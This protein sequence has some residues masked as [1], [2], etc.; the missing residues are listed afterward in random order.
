MR[1]M[2]IVI[3]L[4]T[5]S[6]AF[7]QVPSIEVG[8]SD[9]ARFLAR[10]QSDAILRETLENESWQKAK[11]LS[12][13]SP[14][15]M[16]NRPDRGDCL[17]I[18]NLQIGQ[19]G[20]IGGWD[21]EV[22]SIV[23]SENAILVH[24]GKQL[25]LSGYKTSELSDKMHIRILDPVRVVGNQSFVTVLGKNATIQKIEPLPIEKIKEQLAKDMQAAEEQAKIDAQFH[26]WRSRDG[27][28]VNGRFLDYRSPRV[29][30]EQRDGKKLAFSINVL[31]KE[32]QEKV[33]Q[34]NR[35]KLVESKSKKTDRATDKQSTAR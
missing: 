1:H 5:A 22:Q 27:K 9:A 34:L 14:V 26:D 10:Q 21:F 20:K 15:P 33:R 6:I 35:Q 29:T 31:T 11:K 17:P 12:L 28:S 32:D 30:I 24:A 18:S 23:D 4:S 16:I 19:T 7:A 2:I 13:I 25:W 8:S 3:F